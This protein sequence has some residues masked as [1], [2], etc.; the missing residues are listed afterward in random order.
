MSFGGRALPG[1]AGEA[2]STSPD[3][4]CILRAY[5]LG[6]T[7]TIVATTAHECATINHR[8][9]SR[10]K[11]GVQGPKFKFPTNVYDHSTTTPRILYGLEADISR[12]HNSILR[13]NTTKYGY[14]AVVPRTRYECRRRM[15]ITHSHFTHVSL[16]SVLRRTTISHCGPMN[17]RTITT[18]H[19]SI[20][21]KA[22]QVYGLIIATPYTE[23]RQS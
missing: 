20:R 5:S 2:Y 21:F 19:D 6:H 4:S 11:W 12:F 9:F 1:P 14:A 13:Y 17:I 8:P 22:T 18:S 23:H 7:V 16:T 15:T 3:L 10:D